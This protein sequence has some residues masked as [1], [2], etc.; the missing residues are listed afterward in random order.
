VRRPTRVARKAKVDWYTQDVMVAIREATAE[1]VDAIAH[2]VEGQTKANIVANDQVDTGFMLNSV[3]TVTPRSNTYAAALAKA[4]AQN[5]VRKMAPQVARPKGNVALVA[6]GAG[7]AVYQE[8]QNSFLLKA[9]GEAAGEAAGA[10]I[11]TVAR[12]RYLTR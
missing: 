5:P 6:V 3:Y 7:Y 12:K 2:Q 11:K 8:L 1:V 4:A 10:E 9:A